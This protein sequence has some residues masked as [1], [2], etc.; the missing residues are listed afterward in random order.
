MNWIRLKK[1]AES[2]HQTLKNPRI[3]KNRINW[4]SNYIVNNYNGKME[5]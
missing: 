4:I 2:G 3:L 1:N 5:I